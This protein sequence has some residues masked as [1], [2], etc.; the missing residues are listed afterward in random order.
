MPESGTPDSSLPALEPR[1][2]ITAIEQYLSNQEQE[3]QNKGKEL[4]IRRLELDR[5]AEFAKASLEAQA[6]DRN[7]ER[8]AYSLLHKRNA[9]FWGFI[10]LCILGFA[11]AL[12]LSD[13]D[14][15]LIE[16]IKLV[17]VG[18]GGFGIGFQRG[19][20]TERRSQQAQE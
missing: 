13:K 10:V 19:R 18:A 7:N 15:I 20:S 17:A 12:I 6:K 8:A 14:S 2:S 5:N 9:Y 3:I 4:E 11:M 16:L 1:L